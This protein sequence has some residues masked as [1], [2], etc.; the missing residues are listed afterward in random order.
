MKNLLLSILFVCTS[1]VSYAQFELNIFTGLTAKAIVTFKNG[2]NEIG[3]VKENTSIVNMS[4]KIRDE[5]KFQNNGAEDF[6]LIPIDDIV[7]VRVFQGKKEETYKDYF[8]IR[9]REHGKK[10]S[11]SDKYVRELLPLSKYEAFTYGKVHYFVN[12]NY[13][14]DFYYLPVGNTDYYFTL[15]GGAKRDKKMAEVLMKLDADCNQLHAYIKENYIDSSNYK[16]AYRQALKVAQ[17]NK[18]KFIAQRVSQ[19]ISK[20]RAKILFL[21]EKDFIFIQQILDKYLEFCGK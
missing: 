4:G 20:T 21:S 3:V 6:R 10:G 13:S 5:I 11:F 15:N 7:S 12:G 1:F 19:G 14:H 8:P 2:T 18:S 9:V 17:N 16:V